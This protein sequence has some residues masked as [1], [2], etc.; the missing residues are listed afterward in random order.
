VARRS[1]AWLLLSPVRR[2]VGSFIRPLP[3][4]HLGLFAAGD[5]V[6]DAQLSPNDPLLRGAVGALVACIIGPLA[7]EHLLVV[8]LPEG[9]ELSETSPDALDVIGLPIAAQHVVAYD[10]SRLETGEP[11][12]GTNIGSELHLQICPATLE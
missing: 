2:S 11:A 4:S 6:F 8:Q 5:R 9:C 3:C 12:E 1:F 7:R 10:G